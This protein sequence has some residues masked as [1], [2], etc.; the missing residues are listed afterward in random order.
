MEVQRTIMLFLLLASSLLLT[1]AH[2]YKAD[3]PYTCMV[4]KGVEEQ[5]QCSNS[6]HEI[7]IGAC[8]EEDGADQC[9]TLEGEL[10]AC[11]KDGEVVISTKDLQ[12]EVD[13]DTW[14]DRVTLS[15]TLPA[16]DLKVGTTTTT[17]Y[18]HEMAEG[19][20]WLKAEPNFDTATVKI[21]ASYILNS[22]DGVCSYI[23]TDK[24][25]VSAPEDAGFS[26]GDANE[27]GASESVPSWVWIVCGV[28]IGVV[29]VACLGRHVY[30]RQTKLPE[31][32]PE[33]DLAVQTRTSYLVED[34]VRRDTVLI[35]QSA[36]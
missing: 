18:V 27:D 4:P 13:I 34:E 21:W 30:K 5:D 1:D 14:A 3:H 22:K 15:D 9:M 31:D 12:V 28:V 29:S 2:D 11:V 17:V 20:M 23:T 8:Y 19:T 33:V 25:S 6:P 35:E 36:I 10:A 24:L 16:F 32:I 26:L 7:Q